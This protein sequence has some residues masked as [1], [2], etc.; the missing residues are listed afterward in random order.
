MAVVLQCREWLQMFFL[1]ASNVH[2]EQLSEKN[3]F[4]E[5]CVALIRLDLNSLDVNSST[6]QEGINTSDMQEFLFPFLVLFLAWTVHWFNIWRSKFYSVN[7][8]LKA[9]T[10]KCLGEKC[11]IFFICKQPKGYVKLYLCCRLM[12]HR[13]WGLLPHYVSIFIF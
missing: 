11:S 9:V 2:T 10:L 4:G 1:H 12:M 6:R 5:H 3:E 13:K 8:S 7:F